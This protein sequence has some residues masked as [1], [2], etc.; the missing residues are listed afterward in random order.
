MEGCS[1]ERWERVTVEV[2]GPEAAHDL[3]NKLEEYGR[4]SEKDCP[5]NLFLSFEDQIFPGGIR[6]VF[7]SQHPPTVNIEWKPVK[8]I[9]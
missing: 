3:Q 8:K 5:A 2:D 6:Y 7:V 1:D 9:E 4:A